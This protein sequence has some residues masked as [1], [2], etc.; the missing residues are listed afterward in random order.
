MNAAP[1]GNRVNSK[2]KIFLESK[3]QGASGWVHFDIT[4]YKD[5][6]ITKKEYYGTSL[7]KLVNGNIIDLCKKISPDLL[8]CSGI[9]VVK[10]T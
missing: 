5:L 2:N 4:W 8:N 3:G 7:E 1:I 9:L 10:N 6:D